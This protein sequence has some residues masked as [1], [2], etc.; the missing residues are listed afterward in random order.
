MSISWIASIAFY[1]SFFV[2]YITNELPHTT[3]ITVAAIAALVIALL[4]VFDNRTVF[5]DRR[6]V[7]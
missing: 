3:W 1:I 7:A 5:T 6:P 4:L 2:A